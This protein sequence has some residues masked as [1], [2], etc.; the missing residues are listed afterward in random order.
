V[1]H[2]N[3]AV[4]ND[5]AFDDDDD[6]DATHDCNTDKDAQD[7]VKDDYQQNDNDIN[8]IVNDHDAA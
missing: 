5:Y 7:N 6:T 4:A 1:H 2:K 8:G 3:K